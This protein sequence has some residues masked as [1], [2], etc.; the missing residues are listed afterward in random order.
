MEIYVIFYYVL[1]HKQKA[2]LKVD[3]EMWEE[4]V[5]AL[6]DWMVIASLINFQ[7]RGVLC[8]G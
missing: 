1:Q 6:Q 4:F 7:E 2:I 5:P 3:N 8:N